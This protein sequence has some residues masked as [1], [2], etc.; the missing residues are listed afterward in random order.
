MMIKII[1]AVSSVFLT[2]ILVLC[3]CGFLYEGV[4]LIDRAISTAGLRIEDKDQQHLLYAFG[5]GIIFFYWLKR[6][7]SRKMK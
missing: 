5:V 4:Y 6:A 1:K 2:I 7:I 3:I